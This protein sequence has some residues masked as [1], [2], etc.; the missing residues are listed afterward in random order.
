MN[1]FYV[2]VWV[3]VAGAVPSHGR[4]ESESTVFNKTRPHESMN[5][6]TVSSSK[7]ETYH[8]LHL[9]MQW[10][11]SFCNSRPPKSLCRQQV[12]RHFTVHGLW[13]QK[14]QNRV[15]LYV[16][17]TSIRHRSFDSRQ[18]LYV[19]EVQHKVLIPFF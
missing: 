16:D 17:C 6:V 3:L 19:C 8:Y 9:A 10:P 5:N 2:M 14:F 18:V 4:T 1:V 13:P 15:P 7:L 11:M 12:P